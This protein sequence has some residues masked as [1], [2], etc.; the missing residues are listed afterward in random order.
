MPAVAARELGRPLE[1]L[2]HG[3][4]LAPLDDHEAVEPEHRDEDD[5]GDDQQDQ[6]DH[7]A[8]VEEDRREQEEP[9]ALRLEDVAD[10]GF[11]AA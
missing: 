9:V 5:P 3:H 6:P 8:D 1:R 7:E 4:T 10:L 2:E 11:H